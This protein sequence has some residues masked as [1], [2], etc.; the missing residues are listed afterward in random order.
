MKNPD[1]TQF[2]SSS[3]I[4][5]MFTRNKLK[6]KTGGWLNGTQKHPTLGEA[7]VW[8]FTNPLKQDKVTVWDLFGGSG[9]LTFACM[10]QGC[11]VV[12]T[13][14]D[15]VQFAY[16]KNKLEGYQTRRSL[17]VLGTFRVPRQ[18]LARSTDYP[19]D[20]T[21]KHWDVT[22]NIGR[23]LENFRYSAIH[24]YLPVRGQATATSKCG[25][26]TVRGCVCVVACV[27]VHIVGYRTLQST[28]LFQVLYPTMLFCSESVRFT[29]LR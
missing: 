12:Y 24:G 9:A 26:M 21:T 23:E 8:M 28:F 15:P 11:S 17:D 22:T 4:H 19:L 27:H 16:V 5:T 6:N 7:A 20:W 13:E 3:V 2:L 1:F 14:K 25:M 29:W 10:D 18:L